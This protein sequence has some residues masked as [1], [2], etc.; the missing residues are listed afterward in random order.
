MPKTIDTH[1]QSLD[2]VRETIRGQFTGITDNQ[3]SDPATRLVQ[4]LSLDGLDC[5]ELMLALESAAGIEIP[6]EYFEESQSEM[7]IGQ[8]ADIVLELSRNN[9]PE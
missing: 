6:D 7:T 4:D 3:I 8:V 1:E 5:I 9:R 2:V